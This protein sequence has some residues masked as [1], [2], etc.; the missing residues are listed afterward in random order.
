MDNIV[1]YCTILLIVKLKAKQVFTF[2]NS[3]EVY[4]IYNTIL[5][6]PYFTVLY[7]IVSAELNS[8]QVFT[9]IN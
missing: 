9:L 1:V 6:S 7:N 3:K 4:N 5:S 2:T 8:I